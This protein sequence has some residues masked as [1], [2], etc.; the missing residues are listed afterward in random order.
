MFPSI[1]RPSHQIGA[2]QRSLI[3]SDRHHSIPAM[4]SSLFEACRFS[5]SS[6]FAC[7]RP[8]CQCCRGMCRVRTCAPQDMSN[9]AHKGGGRRAFR[10]AFV[11]AAAPPCPGCL[12]GDDGAGSQDGVGKGP[13]RVSPWCL[14][15][16]HRNF[17]VVCEAWSLAEVI[18]LGAKILWPPCSSP[19]LA[20]C[21]VGL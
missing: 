15:K 10:S 17:S 9:S 16:P 18:L 4:S 1:I 6:S 2:P 20:A 14:S 11:K 19:P 21:H 8:G 13:P 12:H 7:R 5:S 3:S